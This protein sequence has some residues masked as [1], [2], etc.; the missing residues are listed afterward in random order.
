MIIKSL[1]A[2]FRD[3]KNFEITLGQNITIISGYNGTMKST[4]LGLLIQPFNNSRKS[5]NQKY[6]PKTYISIDG[7]YLEGKFEKNI[8]LA[9]PEYD[10]EDCLWAKINFLNTEINENGFY[11]YK[12]ELRK[13]S[14]AKK[15]R[16]WTE[17]RTKGSGFIKDIPVAA[18]YLDRLFPLSKI[19]DKSIKISEIQLDEKEL[20]LYHNW[21]N[22]IL[23]KR[24]HIKK[25]SSLKSSIKYTANIIFEN[26]DYRS[27][28]S[29]ED[30]IGKILLMILS[31]RRVKS[32]QGTD[33]KGAV[34]VID[35]IESSLHPPVQKNLIN[36]LN[37]IASKDNIQFIITTHSTHIIEESYQMRQNS[38]KDKKTHDNIEIIYL[39]KN[40]T[41]ITSESN[42]PFL[43][44]KNHLN[45]ISQELPK[46]K[47]FVED[48]EA[49]I[50][51]L[52]L[53]AP[54]FINNIYI[55]VTELGCNELI[56]LFLNESIEEINTSILLLDGDARDNLKKL[57]RSYNKTDFPENITFLPSN[58]NP[59]KYIYQFLDNLEDE[60]EFWTLNR[61]NTYTKDH[62]ISSCNPYPTRSRKKQKEWFNNY[63]KYFYIDTN[64][65]IF[66]YILNERTEEIFNFN[67]EFL[68]SYNALAPH[69]LIE[70]ISDEDLTYRPQRNN[71]ENQ[72]IE[73]IS[74]LALTTDNENRKLNLLF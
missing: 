66:K 8:K 22:E 1:E 20:N 47:V 62:F 15:L 52:N 13:D 36:F 50:I 37:R 4:I 39:R 40:S 58:L 32:K 60:H 48:N 56:R 35:E 26:R 63:Y 72:N 19:D 28:S 24:E 5:A 14:S 18:L 73:L 6:P 54:I 44:I 61:Y 68:I 21:Y 55:K 70:S 71:F 59:E 41:K 29:G 30:V 45:L 43:S 67:S 31:I 46:I 25:I 11:T 38:I 27:M 2:N 53:L 34:F 16:V 9:Y 49:Q 17:T 33:Y 10:K 12:S 74:M 7:Q 65:N 64:H 69:Y 3:L 23:L 42:P 51:A 57:M